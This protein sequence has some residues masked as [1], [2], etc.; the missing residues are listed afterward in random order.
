M[1]LAIR[2]HSS[3]VD[4]WLRCLWCILQCRFLLS[5]DLFDE[6]GFRIAI[7]H[8][9]GGGELGRQWY[10]QGKGRHKQNGFDDFIACAEFLI[11]YGYTTSE[12]LVISGGSAGG[13]LVAGS[14]NQR[15]E[16]FGGLR[17]RSPFCRC[18]EH[19]AKSPLASYSHR[20]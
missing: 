1:H 14:L 20:I 3:S 5:L 9:R 2:Y 13:L 15:P 18:H 11:A 6:T 8:V 12:T 19:N 10:N 7:A 16:L 17:C 4:G